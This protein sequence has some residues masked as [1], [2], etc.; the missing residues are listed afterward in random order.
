MKRPIFFCAVAICA[1]FSSCVKDS[2]VSQDE[3]RLNFQFRVANL[4]S[5]I[6]DMATRAYLANHS[7][8]LYYLLY[9]DK[10]NLVSRKSQHVSDEGFGTIQ[11]TVVTGTY[12][13]LFKSSKEPILFSTADKLSTCFFTTQQ[14]DDDNFYLKSVVKLEKSG[15]VREF[16][17]S[18]ISSMLE[19]Q[20]EEKVP[21]DVAYIT[22]RVNNEYDRFYPF[23]GNRTSSSHLNNFSNLFTIKR[24][25]LDNDELRNFPRL[26]TSVFNISTP[27]SV[28]IEAF[29]SNDVRVLSFNYPNLQ[30]YENKKTVLKGV[31][32]KSSESD[33]GVTVQSELEEEITIEI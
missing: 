6:E 20:L 28:V 13:L 31:L 27:V 32:F 4:Q 2:F 16:K 17:L 15:G 10:G 7:N 29:N 23:T 5:S 33:F 30:C 12:T 19:L 26:S 22:L 8:Y 11:E 21:S 18:R 14:V 9:D 25:T 1:V 24:L 3:T